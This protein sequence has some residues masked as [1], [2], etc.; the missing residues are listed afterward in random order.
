MLKATYHMT[1]KKP[2]SDS[3][4]RAGRYVRQGSGYRAFIPSPLPPKPPNTLTGTLQGLLSKADRALGRLDG[5]IHTLPNPDLFVFMYMRKEAVLSSQIEGTQSSLQD[6]L[7]A[8]AN[9]LTLLRRQKTYQKDDDAY[10]SKLIWWCYRN[11]SSIIRGGFVRFIAQYMGT[12]PISWAADAQ[13]LPISEFSRAIL[14]DPDNPNVSNLEA[15]I[16]NLIYNLYGLKDKEI[17]IIEEIRALDIE[18]AED[19]I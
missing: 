14:A 19:V 15:D 11:I 8:E 12:I 4:T 10:R 5:S 17:A 9:I 2:A 1:R 3:Y 18:N 7:A 13:K 16:N 6:L